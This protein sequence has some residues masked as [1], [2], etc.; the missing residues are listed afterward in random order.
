MTSVGDTGFWSGKDGRN[1]LRDFKYLGVKWLS[2]WSIR[3]FIG[4]SI[5]GPD[6][7]FLAQERLSYYFTRRR[8]LH[9]RSF[10][11]GP[12]YFTA[13]YHKCVNKRWKSFII[14]DRHLAHR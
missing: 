8:E 11:K 14:D 5:F 13:R 9:S 10:K 1:S 12:K 3:Y 4:A 6:K 7:T 2:G